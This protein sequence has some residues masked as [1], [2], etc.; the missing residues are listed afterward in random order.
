MNSFDNIGGSSVVTATTNRKVEEGE[1]LHIGYGAKST[2][3]YVMNYGF[4]SENGGMVNPHDEVYLCLPSNMVPRPDDVS[5]LRLLS[6]LGVEEWHLFAGVGFVCPFTLRADEVH[7]FRRGTIK[8]TDTR[9]FDCL[10]MVL[11]IICENEEYIHAAIAGGNPRHEQGNIVMKLILLIFDTR[12]HNISRCTQSG[13]DAA[14]TGNLLTARKALSAEYQLLL[15]WRHAVCI[16]FKL[17]ERRSASQFDLPEEEHC[18]FCNRSVKLKACS[19]CKAVKY[20]CV[21]C[22]RSLERWS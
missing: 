17:D 4:V 19:R 5:R 11:T 8:I 20:C 16:R 21:E 13:T 22:Q 9:G 18:A 2:A 14:L 1:E 12:L 7:S 3:G 6:M 10:R 15:Q